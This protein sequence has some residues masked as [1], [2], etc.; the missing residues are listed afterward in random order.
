[1]NKK[2]L[3]QIIIAVVCFSGAGIV[4]YTGLKG[5]SQPSSAVLTAGMDFELTG[6]TKP[7]TLLPYGTALDFDSVFK[8][9]KFI[10]GKQDY[11]VLDPSS[12][13]GVNEP[14][15]I[16]PIPKSSP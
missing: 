13:I 10:Y 5:P 4:L 3:I 1:M 6:Q 16:K 14:D 2:A 12:E 15:L 9:Y 11:P 7:E 8:K